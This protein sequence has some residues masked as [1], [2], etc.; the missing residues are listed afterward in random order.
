MPGSASG[1]APF[2][3]EDFAA[4]IRVLE[5]EGHF[6]PAPL[7]PPWADPRPDLAGDHA[8][9]LTLLELAYH[10]DGAD[11]NGVFGALNGIRCCGA[12]ITFSGD[13]NPAWRL[14]RG[15]M[16]AA[17]WQ[18]VRARWLMPHLKALQELL[19]TPAA[20]KTE[21]TQNP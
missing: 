18:A 10:R 20:A 11:P 12:A 14:T 7:D 15:E 5:T 9:W 21:A 8:C 6:T 3:R 13:A 4:F 19:G 2:R 1:D 16:T 17:E